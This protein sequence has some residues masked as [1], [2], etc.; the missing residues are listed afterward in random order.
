VGAIEELPTVA[1]IIRSMM[2]EAGATLARL[3]ALEETK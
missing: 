1:D 2:E 3:R